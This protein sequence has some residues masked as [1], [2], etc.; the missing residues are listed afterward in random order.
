MMVFVIGGVIAF[1]LPYVFPRSDDRF[2]DALLRAVAWSAGVG[3]AYLV[4]Q[5]GTKSGRIK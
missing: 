2:M 1:L 5:W 4:L 3:A